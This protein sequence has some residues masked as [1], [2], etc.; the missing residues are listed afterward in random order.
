MCS[1]GGIRLDTRLSR[2]SSL[3]VVRENVG[4]PEYCLNGQ[5]MIFCGGIGIDIIT[6]AIVICRELGYPKIGIVDYLF[7]NGTLR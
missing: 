4:R 5:W 3:E 7:Q 1:E 6:D 2:L